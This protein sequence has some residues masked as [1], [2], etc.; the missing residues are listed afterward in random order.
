MTHGTAAFHYWAF[1][2][3]L[4]YLYGEHAEALA[5]A[6]KADAF[7]RFVP[8]NSQARILSFDICIAL[9]GA[10]PAADPEEAARRAELMGRHKALVDAY[11]AGAPQGFQHMKILVEAEMARTDG[12]LEKAIRFY[13]QAIALSHENRAPHI[14]A[15]ANELC[16]KFYLRLGAQKAAG[17][18]LKDA[19]RAY[20]H[21]GAMAKAEALEADYGYVMPALGQDKGRGK[22]TTT[23]ST[24][25]DV[26]NTSSG[27]LSRTSLG[28]L[29]DA[30]LVVRATQA[31]AGAVDLPKVIDKLASL[32]LESGRDRCSAWPGRCA[33]LG[34]RR[35]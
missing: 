35:C 9:L 30:S 18:Y 24:S 17:S 4:H 21:W 2:L 20:V 13:D 3:V 34:R 22:R 31:I 15:L 10:P 1:K 7:S 12:D 23:T 14:E 33:S 25:T 29:R 19:Y 28:S 16:G 6:E 27:L 32:V 8:G 5:A 11:A 26:R